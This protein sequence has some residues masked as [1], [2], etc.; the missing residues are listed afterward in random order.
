MRLNVLTPEITRKMLATGMAGLDLSFTGT[1]E[2]V[3][4]LTLGYKL[5]RQME[6]FRMFR[7][8]GYTNQKIKLYLPLNAPGETVAAD[9]RENKGTV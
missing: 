5:D 1:Q 3:D 9:H 6:A 8:D 7:A 2:I 4:N